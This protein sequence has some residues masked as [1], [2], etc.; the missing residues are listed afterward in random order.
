VKGLSLY[1]AYNNCLDVL[2]T[3]ETNFCNW[4]RAIPPEHLAK[5]SAMDDTPRMKGKEIISVHIARYKIGMTWLFD[6]IS[7]SESSDSRTTNTAKG[8]QSL[9]SI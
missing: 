8:L 1:I 2:K 6:M 4:Q 5:W 9:V 3:R 7:L